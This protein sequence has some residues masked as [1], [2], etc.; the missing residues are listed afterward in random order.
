MMLSTVGGMNLCQMLVTNVSHAGWMLRIH[1]SC[2]TQ[3]TQNY[4][5]MLVFELK[6]LLIKRLL[7]GF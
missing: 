3:G 7:L 6:L 5:S 2:S 4:L 1:C